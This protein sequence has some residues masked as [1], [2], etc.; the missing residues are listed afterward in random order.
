MSLNHNSTFSPLSPG[1]PG[2]PRSPLIPWGGKR[3]RERESIRNL[4]FQK[5]KNKDIKLLQKEKAV[6]KLSEPVEL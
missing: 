2:V 5:E 4:T 1:P 6:V 3:E